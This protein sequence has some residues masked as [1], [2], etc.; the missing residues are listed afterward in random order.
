MENLI[1][2]LCFVPNSYCSSEVKRFPQEPPV[3]GFPEL[4]GR[5]VIVRQEVPFQ[6]EKYTGKYSDRPE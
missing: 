2:L 1:S 6:S 3:K 5:Q 4:K